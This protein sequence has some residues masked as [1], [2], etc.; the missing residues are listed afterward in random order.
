MTRVADWPALVLAAGLGTRLGPLS[1]L[2]A[3]AALPVAGRPLID[4]ILTQLAEA[5]VTRVVINLHHRADSITHIVGDGDAWG[6]QVRY[7]WEPE[8]LGSAGGP[9]RALPLLES[10]RFF[11][12]NGDT[13]SAVRLPDIGRAHLESGAQVTLAAG[14]AD[15]SRYNALL[16]DTTGAYTGIAPRGSALAP[17]EGRSAWHFVGVQAVNASAFAGVAPDRPADSLRQVYAGLPAGSVRVFPY[18]GAF[19]DIGTPRDYLATA[20]AL[21]AHEG[22]PLDRGRD[23]RVAAGAEVEG[24]VLWDRVQVHEGASVWHC[25]VTDDVVIAGGTRYDRM[26]VTPTGDYPL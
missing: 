12:V 1:A 24:S 26:V 11:I 18:D 2:R 22:R 17:A 20:T 15:L 9:A 10:D 19:H 7:S 4:R 8:V 14:P 23:T 25:I 6:L 21:A 16:A 3:K 13:L 5:A